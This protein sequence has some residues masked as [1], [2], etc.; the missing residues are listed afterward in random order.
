MKKLFKS[1]KGPISLFFKKA[2]SCF[3]S[4]FVKKNSV[5]VKEPKYSF[6]R[7]FFSY[8]KSNPKLAFL[9]SIPSIIY[10]VYEIIH[11]PLD[12]S[13]GLIIALYIA[14]LYGRL[15]AA[16]VEYIAAFGLGWIFLRK[17]YKTL[18]LHI[19]AT[20][21]VSI[22]VF[23]SFRY[24]NTDGILVEGLSL[25]V[26]YLILKYNDNKIHIKIIINRIFNKDNKT[27]KRKLLKKLNIK[28]KKKKRKKGKL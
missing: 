18:T 5:E 8:L 17:K 27:K 20:I 6:L 7:G 26:L 24:N 25:L 19:I 3:K 2:F 14:D 4:F 22:G 23:I 16:I 21:T 12:V 10:I 28:M 15:I 11:I 13:I 1:L 9:K